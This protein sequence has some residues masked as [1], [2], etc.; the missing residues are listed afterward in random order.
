[1]VAD[2]RPGRPRDP[3]LDAAILEA[4]ADLFVEHG[5]AGISIEGVAAAAGVGK[6]T[7]YRRFDDKAQ[8]VVAAVR[9]GAHIVDELP[10]TGDLR[11]DLR[12]MLGSL[13]DRLRGPQGRLL[14]TFAAERARHPDLAA[15]FDRAVV[16]RKRV[17]V[18]RLLEA[19]AER[20]ELPPGADLELMAEAGP[21]LL[22]HH[23]LHGLGF[24]DDL[25][26]RIIDLVLGTR[27]D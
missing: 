11:A 5:Y 16:G 7:I 26:D 14:V 6:A 20:G 13:F 22:W 12:A 25:L 24:P 2:V 4:A 18:R 21:A 3:A 10:D 19:A 17:H 8:L 9:D 15:E 27:P 1:M 23:A